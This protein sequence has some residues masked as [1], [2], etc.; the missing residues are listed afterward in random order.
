MNH[1]C[2]TCGRRG[3]GTIPFGYALDPDTNRLTENRTEQ[4]AILRIIEL[5]TRRRV[6]LRCIT[7]IM[8]AEGH[9]NRGYP[10]NHRLI[11]RILDRSNTR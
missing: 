3:G 4:A 1:V 5:Y 11:R 7:A 10:W 8:D 9:Q 2:P 6:S